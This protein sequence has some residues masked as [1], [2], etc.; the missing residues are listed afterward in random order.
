MGWFHGF[1]APLWEL[2]AGNALFLGCSLLY[3]AWWAVSFRPGASGF[4]P[5][6]GV[7]LAGAFLTGFAA[8]YL[9]GR[10]VA[11]LAPRS[12]GVPVHWVLLGA[13]VSYAVLLV[14]TAVCF[15]RPVTSELLI[16]HI[17][18]AVE[19]SAA[20][21]LGGTG[22]VAPAGA[23]ALAV[24]VGAATV[25]GVICYVAY[26]HLSSAAGYREGMVPLAVDAAVMA[27]F[28]AVQALA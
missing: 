3:L 10:G 5:V 4:G 16:M 26:Y 17:W 12:H 11:G 18:A 8:L 9:L 23:A 1:S 20:A 25:A 19:L 28:L 2:F 21:V 13:A 7:C 15:H 22:R 27:V 14:V 6:G 24:L